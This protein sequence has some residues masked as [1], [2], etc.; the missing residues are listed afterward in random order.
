MCGE[1]GKCGDKEN[2]YYFH[3]E[4]VYRSS[5]FSHFQVSYFPIKYTQTQHLYTFQGLSSPRVAAWSLQEYKY[6]RLVIMISVIEL[7]VRIL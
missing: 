3:D 1:A 6:E 7:A 2:I 5:F 4:F